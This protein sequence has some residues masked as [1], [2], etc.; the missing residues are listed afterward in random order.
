MSEFRGISKLS[1][2]F[3]GYILLSVIIAAF[4]FGFLYY[5]SISVAERIVQK[6][7][8]ELVLITEPRFLFWLGAICFAAALTIFFTFFLFFS[9]QK[10]HYL[11]SI[12]NAV[13]M[14]EGGRL[15]LQIPVEGED[16]LS[17]LADSLNH[18]SVTLLEYQESEKAAQQEK[19]ELVRSLSHDIR[20]PLTAII[21]YSDFISTGKYGNQEIREVYTK[22]IQEK[23]C[24]ILELTDLLLTQEE[25]SIQPAE[26]LNGRLLFQQLLDEFRDT[27]EEE[28]YTVRLSEPLE[29]DFDVRLEPQD[30]LRIFDNLFSNIVKY[31][32]KTREIAVTLTMKDEYLTLVQENR[33]TKIQENPLKSY[34]IGLQNIRRIVTKYTGAMSTTS[35]EQKYRIEIQMKYL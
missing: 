4:S 15:E 20:T 8:G 10:I 19:Q 22:R 30:M 1:M 9:S 3:L 28:G 11:L 6:Q 35:G 5:M 2:E 34:G 17:E 25:Q 14:L 24:R 12:T 18:F 32:D 23:A 13:K 33:M 26:V 21:S 27:L 7:T 29:V 31:A 16:E